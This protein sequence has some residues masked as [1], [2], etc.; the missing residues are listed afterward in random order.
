MPALANTLGT[1]TRVGLRED[2]SD[3]IYDVSKADTP[4]LS[5]IQRG[6]CSAVNTDWQT[7]TLEAAEPT[8]A[9]VQGNDAPFVAPAATVRRGNYTQIMTEAVIISG[10]LEAVSKAGRASELVREMNKKVKK[11]KRSMEARITGNYASVAPV[12][13]ATAGQTAGALGFM[14][15]NV[16]R[17]ATGAN[18]VFTGAYPTTAATNGTLR[19]F[20]EVQIQA[21]MLAAFNAGGMPSLAIMP[22]ALK[23]KA[24]TFTGI[25]ANRREAGDSAVTIIGSADV[26][27]SDFGDVQFIADRHCST[28]DVLIIDPEYW[29][30]AFLRPL[31]QEVLA[32]TGDAEKRQLLA[33]FA[34]IARNEASSALIADVQV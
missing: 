33:E 6:T 20:T 17:G 24:S 11:M 5:A 1:S 29:E 31:R 23:Q 19:A 3:K 15:T 34:L 25:A 7:D 18:P 16:S 8:N 32:K 30:V 28:R 13:V 10:T 22:P 27:V 12:G 26:Y 9:Q 4:M 21:A 14:T 2:L